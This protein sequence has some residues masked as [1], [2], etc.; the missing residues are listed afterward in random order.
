MPKFVMAEPLITVNVPMRLSLMQDE[1]RGVRLVCRLR[2]A[3][4]QIVKSGV[5][6]QAITEEHKTE[7]PPRLNKRLVFGPGEPYEL[8]HEEAGR[9][10][11]VNCQADACSS[12]VA[13][14]GYSGCVSLSEN[15]THPV[16]RVRSITNRVQTKNLIQAQ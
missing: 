8:S 15:Q 13:F 14:T 2:D 3:N 10:A 9:V 16:G 1:V 11:S 7:N 5:A 4:G 6:T 12:Y